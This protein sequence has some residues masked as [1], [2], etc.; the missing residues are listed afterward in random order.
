M[1]S[2]E[3]NR[4]SIQKFN[5]DIMIIMI[6]VIFFIVK[7]TVWLKKLHSEILQ[8]NRERENIYNNIIW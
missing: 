2:M 6:I 8:L 1:E 3:S 7:K 4:S 5:S